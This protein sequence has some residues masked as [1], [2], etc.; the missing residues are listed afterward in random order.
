MTN[1]V[2]EQ[3]KPAITDT[4][5]IR[6]AQEIID[7]PLHNST[8]LNNPEEVI[9][10]TQATM[11]GHYA[12]FKVINHGT[13]RAIVKAEWGP[14]KVYRSLKVDM[15]DPNADP[16]TFHKHKKGYGTMH[17]FNILQGLT[18]AWQ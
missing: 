18:D 2:L 9:S 6:A 8:V 7:T 15:L 12:N 13:Q 11:P 16:K 17:E 14:A 1:D 5:L 3:T 4:Q 10:A